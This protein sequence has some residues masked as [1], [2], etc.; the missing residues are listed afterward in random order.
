M[1]KALAQSGDT[2]A[3]AAQFERAIAILGSVGNLQARDEALRTRLE[4]LGEATGAV[5]G[6][7]PL[8][9]PSAAI[10]IGQAA[11]LIDLAA[12]PEILGHEALLL[13]Q[14]TGAA[15]EV[16]LAAGAALAPR[17]INSTKKRS[18]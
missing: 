2:P 5:P 14:T 10:A 16:V 7:E 3:A 15:S 1:L 18:F 12:Y 8:A 6:A 17:R 4:S 11:A 13:L 9:P